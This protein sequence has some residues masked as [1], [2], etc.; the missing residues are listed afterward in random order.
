MQCGTNADGT[1]IYLGPKASIDSGEAGGRRI[2]QFDCSAT[3]L[4]RCYGASAGAS[5]STITNPDIWKTSDACTI[6]T[7]P[8]C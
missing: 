1:A 8:V 7:N 2:A 4:P 3:S 6:Q 5:I